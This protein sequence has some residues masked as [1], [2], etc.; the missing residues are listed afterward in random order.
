MEQLGIGLSQAKHNEDA[1]SVRE[2]ELS[3]KRRLGASENSILVAQGNLA[4][5]YQELGRLEEA[6]CLRR[7]VYSGDLRLH[8]EEH[9]ET[10]IDAH[11]YAN[12]L[13][14][15]KRFGELKPFLRKTM[16]VARRVLGEGNDTTLRLRCIYGQSLYRNDVATLDDLREA[17]ATLEDVERIA[18]RVLGGPHPITV[19]IEQALRCG[20]RVA[21][22]ARESPP[23]GDA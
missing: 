17:V 1:L 23:T 11:N 22:R 3:M 2:A 19:E 18:R 13:L 10:L 7:D 21:L 6:M 15:L 20:A 14:H 12:S 4:N 9:P 16:P 8:G 5:T